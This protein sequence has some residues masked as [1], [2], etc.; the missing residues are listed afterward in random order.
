MVIG[1]GAYC[2]GGPSLPLCLHAAAGDECVNPLLPIVATV[3]G[4]LHDAI[5]GSPQGLPDIVTV[6]ITTV[7]AAGLIYMT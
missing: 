5:Q 6:L 2:R 7:A 3:A 1:L 4:Y